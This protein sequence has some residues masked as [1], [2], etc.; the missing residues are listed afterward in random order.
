M[1]RSL[2]KDGDGEIDY[3][4]FAKK[5]GYGAVS[6]LLASRWYIT[7]VI[8]VSRSAK[9]DPEMRHIMESV[10]RAGQSEGQGTRRSDNMDTYRELPTRFSGVRPRY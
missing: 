4:E 8:L 10:A 9:T 1:I 7:P 3:L 6:V 5:Y 2:D